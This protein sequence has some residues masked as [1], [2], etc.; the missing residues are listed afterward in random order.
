MSPLAAV[1]VLLTRRP[2]RVPGWYAGM[3]RGAGK[4]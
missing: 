3:C 1:L 2:P 4:G